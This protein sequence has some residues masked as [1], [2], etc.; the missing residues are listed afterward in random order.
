MFSLKDLDIEAY[1]KSVKKQ[2]EESKKKHAELYK[3]I[4]KNAKVQSK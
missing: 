2:L 3:H 1:R 4:K